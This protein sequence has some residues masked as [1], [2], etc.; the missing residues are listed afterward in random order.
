MITIE[1]DMQ[2]KLNNMT[3]FYDSSFLITICNK[4]GCAGV[5]LTFQVHDE[6]L[7]LSWGSDGG[8]DL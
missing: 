3:E 7:Y 1:W 5:N 4:H 2:T 8:R 6:L